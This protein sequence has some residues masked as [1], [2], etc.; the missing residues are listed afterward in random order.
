MRKGH[1]RGAAL[2]AL[3]LSLGAVAF[4]RA[5]TIQHQGVRIHIDGAL[6]PTRLPRT[7]LAPVKVSVGTTISATNGKAPP[8][9]HQLTLAINRY[10]RLDRTGLPLC[11]LSEIQPATNERALEVCGGA[12]VGEGEFASTT[13]VTSQVSLPASGKMVAFNG[14]Y[15]GKP[16]ILAHVYG[17][18]PI[19]TSFTLPFVI[20]KAKGTF[21]TTITATLDA[22]EASSITKLDLALNRRFT[23]KGRQRSYLSAS[24][25]APKG[26]P[27]AVFPFAKVSY[28]FTHAKKLSSTLTRSCKARG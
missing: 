23:Y 15:K 26:F 3:I 28:E 19:P 16:A 1:L 12:L 14:T 7:G 4:A 6:T 5:E 8:A 9:L 25:P 17:T 27:G 21:A 10:G 11:Q 13:A 24:C 18:D 20:A 2:G 22:D